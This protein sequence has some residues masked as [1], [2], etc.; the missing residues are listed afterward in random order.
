MTTFCSSC[1]A[2]ALSKARFCSNCGSDLG[3]QAPPTT[4][5]PS[6]SHE[7]TS[8]KATG[9]KAPS[10]PAGSGRRALLGIGVVAIA[11]LVGVV[12]VVALIPSHD[13]SSSDSARGTTSDGV[14]GATSEG[15]AGT[16]SDGV[17]G[18]TSDRVPGTTPPPRT[19]TV[20]EED[21][22]KRTV[23]QYLAAVTRGD[24]E[25]A[26]PLVTEQTRKNIERS[27]RSCADSTSSLNSG[28][29]KAVIQA[30]KD[31]DVENVKLNG[32]RGTADIK[33][34]GMTRKSSLR[35]EGGKW[36]LESTG[37]AG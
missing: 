31:A 17:P 28:P 13:N 24:G 16:S 18:A 9:G 10:H 37:V 20:S 29:S 15:V 36:K 14:P 19:V 35:K 12:T 27:G 30:F 2:Q 33:V 3:A 34:S 6:I 32:D 23:E 1:G 22:A 8:G 11:A 26:C 4:S 7:A 5:F 21:Q 25:A